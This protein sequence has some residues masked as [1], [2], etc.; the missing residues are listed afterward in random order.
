VPLKHG[1]KTKTPRWWR[2]VVLNEKIVLER[3]ETI[4]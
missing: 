3:T 1:P 2:G 4:K